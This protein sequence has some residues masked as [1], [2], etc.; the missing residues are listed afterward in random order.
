MTVQPPCDVSMSSQLMSCCIFSSP[1][2]DHAPGGH[3]PPYTYNRKI[4]KKAFIFCVKKCLVNP[5][6]IPA[7][8]DPWVQIGHAPR[9]SLSAIGL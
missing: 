4:V 9:A 3:W 2:P 5:F 8:R 1:E 6:I 7:N